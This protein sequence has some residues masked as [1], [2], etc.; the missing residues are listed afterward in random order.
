MT[1]HIFFK[2]AWDCILGHKTNL[3]LLLKTEIIQSMSFDHNGIKLEIVN[4]KKTGNFPN[5]WKINNTFLKGTS[6]GA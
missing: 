6:L 3:N 2:N 4:R 5:I 1:V